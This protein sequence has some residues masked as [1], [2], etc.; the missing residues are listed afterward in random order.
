MKKFLAIIL[1]MMVL[2]VVNNT[3]FGELQIV[4]QETM[5]KFMTVPYDV[6]TK[7]IEDGT[8]VFNG[9]VYSICVTGSLD[10]N[11][12]FGFNYVDF[13]GTCEKDLKNLE[14]SMANYSANYGIELTECEVSVV[15][16]DTETSWNNIYLVHLVTT[17]SLVETESEEE[18]L[19]YYLLTRIY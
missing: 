4:D 7:Q 17:K 12:V 9:S 16:I 15:A 19:D 14:R 2:M 1:T 5:I 8:F 13:D 6:K 11:A 3:V 18:Y 10:I